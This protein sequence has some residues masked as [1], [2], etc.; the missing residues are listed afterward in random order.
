MGKADWRIHRR[1]SGNNGI[2][3]GICT[4]GNRKNPNVI[5]IHC[6]IH[7]QALLT[8]ILLDEINVVLKLCINIVNYF[9]KNSSNTL[10]TALDEDLGTEHQ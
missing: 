4:V 5:P 3:L 1:C 10:F 9:K 6:F 8:K 7:R 2:S